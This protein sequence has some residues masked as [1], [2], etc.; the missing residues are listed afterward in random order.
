[1]DL[2]SIRY[3]LTV[4]EEMNI[5]RAAEKL[6]ISQPPLSRAIMDLED[7]LHCTLMIRGK[8]KITLTPEGLALK[9]RGEQLLSLAEMTKEEITEMENG[10]SGTLYLGL[11]EGNGP[12]LAARWL[13][14]F[15]KLYPNVTYELWNGNSDDLTDRLKE[16]LIDLAITMEP[17][18][19]E[20]LDGFHVAEEPWVAVVPK[21]H[22][23]AKSKRK[24]IS[25]HELVSEPLIIPSRRSRRG[26][27][28]E[29]FKDT[30]K[31]PV[32]QVVVAHSTNALELA[33]NGVG[34]AIFPASIGNNLSDSIN[35]T[36]RE[37]RPVIK[38]SYL[39]SWDKERPSRLLATKFIEYVRAL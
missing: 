15:Q 12:Y 25:T 20:M 9:R 38:A 10:I 16:G 8:R 18:N 33:A 5:T 32:Y 21:D 24:T 27:I 36:I 1:M 13:A 22:P 14:G 31:E 30:G 2:R 17:F 35:V 39:L 11:V 29:W 4:A 28:R 3:F 23:L 34:I 19:S 6:H 7:E 37:I 26:E